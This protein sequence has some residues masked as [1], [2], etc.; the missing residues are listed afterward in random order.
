MG[1]HI[2]KEQGL[3]K[4]PQS[5]W[6]ATTELPTFP[7]L[8]KNI[9]TDV[10]VVG[11]GIT[12]ITTA[13]L[14][15]KAGKQVVL[16]DAGRILNGTTG[17]TTAKV[18]AQ[19]GMIYDEL[20]NHFGEEKARFYYEVNHKA[21]NFIGNQIKE[22]NVDCDWKQEDAYIYTQDESNTLSQLKN[23]YK[24]YEKLGIPGEWLE[25]VPLPMSVHGAIKM[26]GQH[27]FH[28]LAYLKRM[29]EEFL[30][31]GGEIYEN[32]TIGEEV[33]TKGPLTIKAE[34][35]N[36]SITCQYAVSASHFPFCDGKGLY[37]TRLHVERSYALAVK[38][39]TAYP[40]G[41]YLSVDKPS[42]SLRSVTYNG[43]ELVI[44]GG[45]N[46][47]TGK[48]ESTHTHY[49]NL[50]KF[51]G[52]LLGA[53]HIPY[54]WS[55]QDLI[56]LDNLPYIGP[57]TSNQ[58]RIL[59]ATGYR[60]WGMTNSTAAAHVMTDYI[61]GKDNRYS[62]LYTPSRF[63][64]DPALKTFIVQNAGVAKEFISGK[65]EMTYHK[66]EHLQAGEGAIVRHNGQ[67]A[68]AYKDEEGNL[69]LLDTTC[70]HLGCETQWNEGERSWD[71]PCH[72][73]RYSYKGEVLE[74]PAIDPLKKLDPHE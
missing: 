29:V 7:R 59:V 36:H 21:M 2:Q 52:E 5:L 6:R 1:E 69:Y 60:K 32:T 27:R 14:L 38:P 73:S 49:E 66:I 41:M 35:G 44:A 17:F 23:E 33:E 37:F 53:R 34:R 22:W 15:A 20:I 19:H 54:R 16:L 25:S 18:T 55:T 4:Y 31:M 71:C 64:A 39:E 62:E 47:P 42:R 74:G 3:P 57:I 13:Y 70:T 28:P 65:T 24:A 61:L 45:E 10:A 30:K 50:E 48:S 40:G 8:K 72:G 26:P 51:A 68:G 43:E 9:K 46:H 12:G 58:D 11:A 67:R 63:K 56:T